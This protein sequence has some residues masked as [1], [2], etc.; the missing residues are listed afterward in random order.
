MNKN[1][2][3]VAVVLAVAVSAVA[4]GA[5]TALDNGNATAA[6][7]STDDTNATDE[8]DRQIHVSATGQAQAEPDQAVVQVAITAEADSVEEIR[9]QLATG[10]AELT[11]ALDELDVEYETTRYDISEQY[12]RGDKQ[13]PFD[14]E[15]T[16]AYKITAEDADRAGAVIDAAAGAGAEVDGVSL[17]LSEQRREQL[18]KTAI[19]DAMQDASSQ[20]GTIASEGG[21][22]LVAPITVDATQRSYSPVAYDTARA[23]GDDGAAPPTEVE[24]G[25]ISVTYDVDVTY[26][27]VRR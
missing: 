24:S 18:R 7:Q 1:T 6:A 27:A 19:E 2:M 25:S 13:P 23:E 15:G 3:L 12:H 22:E 26:E 20:A 8:L 5:L 9:D 11:S 4:A 10:S 14:Y 16:H 21:L 17:T